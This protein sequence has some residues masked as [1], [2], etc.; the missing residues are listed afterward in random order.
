[1]PLISP[2]LGL[3]DSP[4]GRAIAVKVLVPLPP[5]TLSGSENGLPVGVLCAPGLVRAIGAAVFQLNVTA[6]ARPPAS[7]AVT[8]V[9]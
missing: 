6:P 4:V 3:I 9:R 7:V 1:M 2:V 5:V 8:V